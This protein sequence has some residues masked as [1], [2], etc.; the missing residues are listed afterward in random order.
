MVG[1]QHVGVNGATELVGKLFKIVQLE[2]IILC[3]LE[4]D[5]AVIAALEDVPVNAGEGQAGA[6][7][8]GNAQGA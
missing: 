7:G 5:R 6:T 8:H 2:L 3:A 4:T 1:H